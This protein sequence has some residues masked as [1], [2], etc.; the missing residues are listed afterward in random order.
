MCTVL[1]SMIVLQIFW[2]TSRSGSDNGILS[3]V[4]STAASERPTLLTAL[5]CHFWPLLLWLS[6]LFLDQ[7]LVWPC[8]PCHQ[9][10]YVLSLV[11]SSV[12]KRWWSHL[13]LSLSLLLHTHR[14]SIKFELLLGI[15]WHHVYLP[16]SSEVA[17]ETRDN[18]Y[19]RSSALGFDLDY[20]N[21]EL[22]PLWGADEVTV[23]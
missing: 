22:D 21:T 3:I 2:W 11:K 19:C 13:S 8:F 7:A 6:P 1:S 23:R 17:I 9:H 10:Q 20:F 12:H 18:D 5:H 4:H 15:S 14:T 16:V